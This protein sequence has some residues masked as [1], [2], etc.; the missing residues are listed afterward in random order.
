MSLRNRRYLKTLKVLNKFADCVKINNER[1]K[2]MMYIITEKDG[3]VSY[4]EFESSVTYKEYGWDEKDIKKYSGR[5]IPQHAEKEV[6]EQ[7]NLIGIQGRPLFATTDDAN[8]VSVIAGEEKIICAFKDEQQLEIFESF[9]DAWV[10]SR[11]RY[12]VKKAG[13][14]NYPW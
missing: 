5:E 4:I 14:I 12:G 13:R 7:L 1:Y 2:I 11:V 6:R 9:R 3:L 8:C 10:A